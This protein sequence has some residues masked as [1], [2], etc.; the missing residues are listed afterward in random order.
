MFSAKLRLPKEKSSQEALE[1]ITA[2]TLKELGLCAVENSIIGS[3]R[4]KGISGGEKKR[5]SVGLELITRPSVILLDEPVSG[6]D[7]FSA[8]QLIKVL[9]RV[10]NA[11]TGVLFTIHQ[12]SSPIFATFD[13]LIVLNKG[14]VMYQG[15]ANN[16]TEHLR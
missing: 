14:R 8:A 1:C 10:A 6:L 11:G 5:V 7:S 15:H 3:D 2:Q 13:H 16:L 12:P 9:R 4:K